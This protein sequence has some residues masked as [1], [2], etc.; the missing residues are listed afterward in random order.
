MTP[1]PQG[2]FMTS[3]GWKSRE[4][5]VGQIIAEGKNMANILEYLKIRTLIILTYQMDY[6]YHKFNEERGERPRLQ[7]VQ[8][9]HVPTR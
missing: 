3:K 8:S 4:A 2:T 9:T 1:L 7:H 5:R 6:R